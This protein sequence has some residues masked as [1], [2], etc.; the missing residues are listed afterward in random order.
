MQKA[1]SEVRYLSSELKDKVIITIF[2][3][4][5]IQS[6]LLFQTQRVAILEEKVHLYEKALRT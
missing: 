3:K 2:D 4:I 6:I 1:E 5:F